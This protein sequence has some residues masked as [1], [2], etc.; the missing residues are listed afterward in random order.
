[1]D[2]NRWGNDDR[3]ED[4]PVY[5]R[6]FIICERKLTEED[7]RNAF[8]KFGTIEDIK[9]PIDRN[10][11]QPKGIA[12]IKFSRT[13]EAAAALEAMNGKN[14][15]NSHR[16]LKILVASNR[17]EIQSHDYDMDRFKRLFIS[18]SKDVSEDTINNDFKNFGFI[19]GIQVM[20]DRNTG[21][22]K[23][24]AYVKY[25]RFSEAALAYEHCDR[26]YRPIF[27][28]PKTQKRRE[29]MFESNL[30]SLTS[31]STILSMMNIQPRG[32][33]Q[34]HFM[35]SPDLMEVHAARLFSI[36]PG[37]IRCRLQL[38][39]VRNCNR[40]TVE[41]SNPVSAE[42]ALEQLHEFEYP[43]GQRIFV[44]PAYM[45]FAGYE[46]SSFNFSKSYN[47]LRGAINSA[48]KSDTPDLAQLAQAIAEASKL[49]KAATTGF[50]DDN[51]DVNDLNYCSLELPPTQ[52]LAD[53]DSPVAKR[54]FLVCKPQPPPLT[55]LRDVFCRFGNLI[56]V[57]TL[58][59]KTVGFA[60]Y[61]TE[62]SANTAIKALHG[63]EICGVRIKV[64][65]AVEEVPNKR[66]RYN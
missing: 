2:S 10:T 48:K 39:L 34:L 44:K 3:S 60:R 46:E 41:Y 33:T 54:C 66:T 45:K 57:Y 62:E 14:I 6:L 25:Q 17:S 27:A 23:G 21:Q 4:T 11:G 35:C 40:G 43:P 61:A 64:L 59:N 22:S 32:F 38:D 49:I 63:A 12:F 52:P 56:N 30:N 53:I 15:S 24:F 5:S 55:A 16:P 1:M 28:S 13:S 42:Y 65:E 47:K 37:M 58:P 29:T 26:K 19:E 18:I 7:F 51:L 50:N 8:L 31:R 20:T 9:L 36:I